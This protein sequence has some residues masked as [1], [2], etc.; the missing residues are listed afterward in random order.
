MS[1]RRWVYTHNGNPLPEPIEV[2]ADWSDTPSRL[3]VTVDL[4]MDGTRAT[5]GTDI[6]SRTKRRAYMKENGLADAD[7]F[8]EHWAKAEKEQ[9]KLRAGED[10]RR[11]EAIARAMH[12]PSEV[13]RMVAESKA[14]AKRF[15]NG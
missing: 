5:D 12:N 13:R 14:R 4:Y 1:R 8:K 11:R 7:D 10:P 3:P 9:A 6:G 2:T 15:D